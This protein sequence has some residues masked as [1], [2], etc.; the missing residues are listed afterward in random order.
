MEPRGRDR[1]LPRVVG[2][3]RGRAHK[4]RLEPHARTTPGRRPAG[5]LWLRPVADADRDRPAIRALVGASRCR[6]GAFA[7]AA[8]VLFSG[9]ELK[10]IPEGDPNPSC[11]RVRG[12]SAA[13]SGWRA[14]PKDVA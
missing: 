10:R 6:T 2:P 13:H 5:A 4:H 12:E 7:R 3:L 11:T 1:R 14:R 8:A 9:P